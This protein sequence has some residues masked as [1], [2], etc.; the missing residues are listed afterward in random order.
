MASI[1]IVELK[2]GV[3][4]SKEVYTPL[5][6]M[7]FRKGTVL[8]PRE[9]DILR[10]FMVQYVEVDTGEVESKRTAKPAVDKSSLSEQSLS[11]EAGANKYSTFHEEYDKLISFVKSAYQSALAAELPI[12]ELRNQ[13]EATIGQIKDYN[14]LT[15]APRSMNKYDY[16]YHNSV[17]C[18]LSSYL[19]AKWSGLQQKDWMQAAFAG[20]F[21]DIGNIKID[22]AILYKPT[23]LSAAEIEEIRKHTA[24]G[25]QILKNVRAVNEGVR[26]AALQH[27][28]KVD[29]SGYP[30]RLDGSKIHIYAKIVG[31]TDIFHAMTLNRVYQKAQSPYLVLE[32]IHTE[33]FGKLD[34]TL[35]RIFIQKATAI[36]H[37]TMV[38]LSNGQV[39][40]IVFTDSN[41]PT[42]PL[43]SVGGEIINLTQQRQ[44]HIEEVLSSN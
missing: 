29:G 11:D 9:L 6:G 20:L 40:E 16:I 15:F 8:L 22:S 7:L 33:A 34:P 12:Y 18:A 19:L 21:H 2:P 23:S 1:S 3:K 31:I 35:V 27:H 44:L 43:V 42:R 24:Y 25:Y 37:G 30:L 17:L 5:G 13:L 32:Q 4:L 38:R 26:L 41:H 14:P 36:H 10:A 39:G 28:E